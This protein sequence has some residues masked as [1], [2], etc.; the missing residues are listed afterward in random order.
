MFQ[1]VR[2]IFICYENI[3]RSPMAEGIFTNLL[4]SRGLHHYFSVCSAGTVSYQSGSSPDQRAV[5]ALHVLGIDI[6]SIQ[7]SGIDT[8]ELDNF[9]WIFVMDYEN[10]EDVVSLLPV[11]ESPKIH[12]MMEFVEERRHEE[13]RDPYYGSPE[14][15]IQVRDDL[16]L[17]S[18]TILNKMITLY[19]FLE[20]RELNT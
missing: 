2:I 16:L 10:Y 12:R 9:D 5:D 17:A 4:L 3:C 8:L 14:D 20:Q 19:P 15:F 7:A 6:S 1:P 18:E 11:S 13:V